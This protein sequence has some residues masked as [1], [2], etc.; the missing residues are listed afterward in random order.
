MAIFHGNAIPSGA[1]PDYSIDNSCRFDNATSPYM[2]RTPGSSGNRRTYTI[3]VWV[4]LGHAR[5]NGDAGTIFAARTLFSG[6]YNIL[7]VTGNKLHFIN[8]M[9]SYNF[10]SVEFMRDESAWYHIHVKVDTTQTTASERIKIYINGVEPVMTSIILPSLNDSGNINA[11]GVTHYIG[12]HDVARYNY[13]HDGLMSEFHFVDGTALD[14][15]SFG[16]FDATYGHWKPIEV[17]GLTYGTNGFYM[18]FKDSSNLGN[19]VSGNTNDYALA[20]IAASD[21]MTDTPTNN[22]CTWNGPDSSG[23]TLSEG[24]LKAVGGTIDK[25][26]V[27]TFPMSSGKWYW[28]VQTVS[29]GNRN[30]LGVGKFEATYHGTYINGSGDDYAGVYGHDG[31]TSQIGGTENAEVGSAC[32]SGDIITICFDADI[33][34]FWLNKNAAPNTG[35]T[36]LVTG[37]PSGLYNPI[38]SHVGTSATNILNAG[39]D[40]TFAGTKTAQNNVDG[41]GYGNFYYTPP[42]GFLALCTKNISNPAVVPSKHFNT[43]TYDNGAGAKTGVG[44]QPDLVWL[45]SRGS[46]YE[47]EWTDAVRGVTKAL[48]CDSNVAESTD[49]TG[50]TAFGADGFTVGADGNYSDQ[51]GDG[52][53]AWNWKAN[54]SGSSNTDGTINTTSTSAN[55]AAGFSIVSYSGNSTAG[56]TVGHGL[57]VA[58]NLLIIKRRS[59][60]NAWYAGSIQP[61]A[62]MDFTDNIVPNTNGALDNSATGGAYWNNTAPTASVFSVGSTAHYEPV[63]LSGETYVAYCWHSVE[64]YSKIGVYAGNGL[65]DGTFIYTGFA[66]AYVIRKRT[67]GANSWC[68]NDRGRNPYNLANYV[69]LA[70]TTAAEG[71]T[72]NQI[73]FLSNGFKLRAADTN[74]NAT[75]GIYIYMAFAE[76]PFKYAN[77][78]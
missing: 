19:D 20:N 26:F 45:K 50:L 68:I 13:F 74:G 78:R 1:E 23:G 46:A 38:Y 62:S 18:D 2:V 61:F 29:N 58:P 27:G 43:I 17:T 73:D 48:S 59:A 10:T 39:Q 70:D 40:G 41:N 42:T 5:A 63:N 55:V 35:A 7:E 71:S 30:F 72:D 8:G 56:A 37:L 36:A 3:S 44:F 47:H 22:F 76:T 77:A 67:N 16:E 25:M 60:N 33:G 66:P 24:N 15:A 54:G 65:A 12:A 34:S 51:T 6:Y 64:G 4:K 52:M 69:A 28:E 32:A 11:S 57:S 53:V 21:K 9:P 31:A 75:A 49:S 14:P